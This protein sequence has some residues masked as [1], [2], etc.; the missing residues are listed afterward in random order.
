MPTKKSTSPKTKKKPKTRKLT[1]SQYGE[2]AAQ[3]FRDI[4]F[5]KYP[6]GCKAIVAHRDPSRNY[7]KYNQGNFPG[8]FKKVSDRV[9][10]YQEFGTGLDNETFRKLVNIEVRPPP[11]DCGPLFAVE[12]RSSHRNKKEE[13]EESD[14]ESSVGDDDEESED[15]S[16]YR[17]SAKD[18]CTLDGFVVESLLG[19]LK[20]E[21]IG[22]E[23]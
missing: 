15:D 14:E 11:E 6:P 5:G 20:V 17:N 22:E 9:K 12:G 3:L 18:D 13:S 23:A 7:S 10:T 21:D 19:N 8:H 1:W 16:T 2:D 4:Y